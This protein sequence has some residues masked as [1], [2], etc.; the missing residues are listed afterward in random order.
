M[1]LDP[2]PATEPLLSLPL[3]GVAVALAMA[4]GV[5]I[6]AV[7]LLAHRRRR[8]VSSALETG[9]PWLRQLVEA[10]PQAALVLDPA[11]RLIAW[12]AAA[13]RILSIDAKTPVPTPEI[14]A[15]AKHVLESGT[16]ETIELATPDRPERHLRATASPLGSTGHLAGRP[17]SGAG[18]P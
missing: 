18:H 11:G 2:P 9:A 10:L 13:T 6:L 15:L 16:P 4:I 17:G 1:S 5:V 12:N 14:A 8:P 3:A 7:W